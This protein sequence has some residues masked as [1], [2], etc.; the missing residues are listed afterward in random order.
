MPSSGS[1]SSD[2]AEFIDDV[3]LLYQVVTCQAGTLPENLDPVAVE[4]YCAKQRPRFQ[5]FRE[6]WGTTARAF[7][8]ALRPPGLPPE[9]VYP[10]G[11]GDL[12]MALTAY[13]D[14]SPVTTLSLELAGDPRRLRQLKDKGALRQSLQGL[15]EAS[16]STLMS[17]DSKSV[18]MSKIQRGE[19]P[20]QLSMHLM[21]LLVNDQ[22][23]VSVRY[24]RI[25]EDG[26]LHYFTRAEIESLDGQ[27]AGRLRETWKSP[28]F[29][30]AFANVEVQFV[31]V[32]RPDA[33]RRVHRHIAADLSDAGLAK[34]PGVR[35]YLEARGR[36]AMMTKAASYLLWRDDFVTMRSW[37]VANAAFMFS[38]STGVP[39]RWW[40]KAGCTLET[41]GSFQ[42]SFLG[43]WEGYQRELR[44]EFA[45]Q[46][47]RSVPT[48]F[49]Y[50]D[51]SPE[52]RSHLIVTSCPLKAQDAG[53]AP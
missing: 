45:A 33:P 28:D 22:A 48:R 40:K 7:L 47:S 11:G 20:G 34:A 6:H 51:G 12:M 52:K 26:A 24:F 27:K 17:N 38:D 35:R 41:Y 13:P 46:P 30:P 16:V 21:G 8:A 44:E 19:L 49:G 39:P 36:V 25:E 5:R 14:A 2:P 18:T 37:V 4:E 53:S 3:R 10:F 9:V 29:S 1:V 23:P 42:K 50:P 15:A 32:D 31:P 43:T